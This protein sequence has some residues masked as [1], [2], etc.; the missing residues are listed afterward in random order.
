MRCATRHR[1]Y[2]RIILDA[3]APS[4]TL[5]TGGEEEGLVCLSGTATVVADGPRFPVGRHGALCIPRGSLVEVRAGGSMDIAEF[6]APVE[7][8]YPLQHG[9]C[10]EV[11]A[12]P[13]LHVRAGEPA[14]SQEPR[15]SR[16]R[17]RG[18]A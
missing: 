10:A 12:D 14:T 2:G 6:R 1:S 5:D 13:G 3:E 11:T 7:G 16:R 17:R 4:V 9:P 8:R 15:P 18:T